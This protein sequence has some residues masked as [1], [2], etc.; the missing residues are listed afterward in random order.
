[1][2]KLPYHTSIK[3]LPVYNFYEC[4]KSGNL[5]YLWKDE[6]GKEDLSEVWKT[7]YNEYCEAAK[8]DN[9]HLKQIAKVDFLIFKYKRI[10][11]TVAIFPKLSEEN[12]KRAVEILKKDNYFLDLSK[13]LEPQFK[14][15]NSQLSALATKIKIE[16]EK[17]PKE[18]KK[19]AV[20]L[21]KQVISLENMKPGISIDI[22]TETMEKWLARMESAA[23][24]IKIRNAHNSVRNGK[25]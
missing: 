3:T 13:D 24:E 25:R 8:I 10:S 18:D 19:E 11:S 20:S 17:L 5:D 2:V 12:Q 21:M 16:Q 7:I 14:R 4:L 15:I 22:Y 23:E 9:R 1:M 6:I